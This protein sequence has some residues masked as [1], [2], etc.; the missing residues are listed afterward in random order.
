[1]ITTTFLMCYCFYKH[2]M[3][4]HSTLDTNVHNIKHIMS[5]AKT[6]ST[7]GFGFNG[8]FVNGIIHHIATEARN[9][10]GLL[11]EICQQCFII[12][13]SLL[14]RLSVGVVS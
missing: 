11:N 12:N 10:Q 8:I 4:M 1:M 9:R 5:R 14:M 6:L 7:H 3:G 2:K 13:M